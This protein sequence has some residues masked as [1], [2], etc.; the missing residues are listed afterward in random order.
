MFY[1]TEM[2]T[3]AKDLSRAQSKILFGLAK[4]QVICLGAAAIIGMPLFFWD[5]GALGT[6]TTALCMI[7][8]MLH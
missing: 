6:T 1:F 5:W 4:R 3:I 8:V 2:F 7:L